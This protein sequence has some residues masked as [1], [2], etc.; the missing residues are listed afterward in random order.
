MKIPTSY[1]VLKKTGLNYKG[2]CGGSN[3]WHPHLL[4][5]EGHNFPLVDKT[6]HGLVPLNGRRDD[7]DTLRGLKRSATFF[8]NGFVNDGS[9]G[10]PP[11]ASIEV[12]A[13]RDEYTQKWS[14]IWRDQ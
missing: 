14:A 2:C 9:N 11:I 5:S 12:V 10:Y 7:W 13:W 3:W 6:W 1:T 4:D 8:F